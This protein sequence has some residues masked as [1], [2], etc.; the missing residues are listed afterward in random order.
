MSNLQWQQIQLERIM[1]KGKSAYVVLLVKVGLL[2]SLPSSMVLYQGEAWMKLTR[3]SHHWF[4]SHYCIKN[5]WE[6]LFYKKCKI[7]VAIQEKWNGS[8]GDFI[9][10]WNGTLGICFSLSVKQQ[11]QKKHKVIECT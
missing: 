8:M 1:L 5:L 7:A 3:W 2:Y 6:L 10:V 9:S 11:Q 4:H